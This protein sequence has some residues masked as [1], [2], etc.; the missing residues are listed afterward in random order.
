MLRQSSSFGVQAMA[1]SALVAS[2]SFLKAEEAPPATLTLDQIWKA[3]DERQKSIR[4]IRVQY[5]VSWQKFFDTPG[6]RSIPLDLTS[7][8]VEFALDGERRYLEQKYKPSKDPNAPRYQNEVVI[9]DGR[10]TFKLKRDLGAMVLVVPGKER[11]CEE[12]ELYCN[13]ALQMPYSDR[14]RVDLDGSYFYP[15]CLRASKPAYRVLPRQELSDGAWCHVVVLEQPLR[16][17]IW[18]D[19]QMGCAIR[20]REQFDKAKGQTII[21]GRHHHYDF[22]KTDADVWVPRKFTCEYFA[23]AVDPPEF[24]GKKYLE[25]SISVHRVSINRVADDVFQPSVLPG[26]IVVDDKGSYRTSGDKSILLNQ[27]AE[28]AKAQLRD[29]P[30]HSRSRLFLILNALVILA[31]ISTV[32]WR[33]LRTRTR[34][35]ST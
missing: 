19:P 1:L 16:D 8:Q 22:V 28:S 2:A 6:T 13:T 10:S 33:Y 31:I 35:S 29:E 34:R 7:Y 17:K 12:G 4:N 24:W 14:A 9:F 11:T 25:M 21:N 32:T 3:A 27:L 18:V 20:Q 30:P 5:D 15:H 23:K 26:T